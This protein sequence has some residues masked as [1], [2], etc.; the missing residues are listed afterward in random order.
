[1]TQP[2]NP[3]LSLVGRTVTDARGVARDLLAMRFD[4]GTLWSMLVLVSILSVLA[5]ETTQ[6]VIPVNISPN[7]VRI[8]PYALTVILGSGLVMMVF[9]FYFV[10]QVMGGKA[11][12]PGA[13]LLMIWWQ[14]MAMAL[15]VVQTLV[16]LLLPFL[17]NLISLIGLGY[18]FYLLIIFVD[19]MH[20]F[21]NVFRALT[22]IVLAMIGII[23][24]LSLILTLIGATAQGA[25]V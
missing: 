18:M 14:V 12:F 16:L 9:A 5:F 19:E 2:T 1:M 17:A 25:L 6:A 10:G 21:A 11:R 23:V 20:G 7:M 13:L 4:R 24:G 8:S 22:T 3:W 15:Q